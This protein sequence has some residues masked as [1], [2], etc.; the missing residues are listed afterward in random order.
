MKV[1]EARQIY[2]TQL[3]QYN[4]KKFELA[5]QKKEWEEH[6]K[7][8]PAQIVDEKQGVLLD[9]TYQ[10]V[11]E[12]QNEYQKYMDKLMQQWD[13]KFNQVALKQQE[14]SAK[15]Y[16]EEMSKLL[17]V[18][19]RIMHGDIVP[20]EDERKLMEFDKDL[21]QMAKNIGAMAQQEK[22][23][24]YKSLWDD[25]DKT[26]GE[27]PMEAADGEEAFA[28]GPEVVSVEDTVAGVTMDAG[29]SDAAD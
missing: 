27:D 8:M 1:G 3:K 12:K 2:S 25:E 21:Y 5:Q 20:L 28:E 7:A 6:K 4:M 16:G 14:E 17:T 23:H 19:R 29:V 11:S 24:K 22:K 10:A 9:L 13:N 26:P 18:A 15:E